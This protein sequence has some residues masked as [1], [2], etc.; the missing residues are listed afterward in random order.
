MI[1]RVVSRALFARIFERRFARNFARLVRGQG[2]DITD[3]TRESR[4][5]GVQGPRG[6]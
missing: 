4:D 6:P 1:L 2:A 3:R 5:P